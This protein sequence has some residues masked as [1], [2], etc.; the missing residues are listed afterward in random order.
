MKSL[1]VAIYIFIAFIIFAPIKNKI[2]KPVPLTKVSPAPIITTPKPKPKPKPLSK[3]LPIIKPAIEKASI[4][5]G[6]ND[7]KKNAIVITTKISNITV[8]VPLT[9]VKLKEDGKLSKPTIV[10]AEDLNAR[11]SNV[12]SAN[13]LKAY[14]V[15]LFFKESTDMQKDSKQ[16]ISKIIDEMKKREPCVIKVAGFSDTFGNAKDNMA[17]SKKRAMMVKDLLQKSKDVNISE[18][19]IE[20]FGETELLVPTEDGIKEEKNRRVEITI[21]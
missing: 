13:P 4:I 10:S 17:I 5:L 14:H 20:I 9:M 6:K 11:F 19:N 21:R 18:I 12:M 16:L 3:P 8:D 7:S 1:L 2:T 15:N